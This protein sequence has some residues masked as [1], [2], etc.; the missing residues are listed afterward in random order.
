MIKCKI[1][2][3]D[4]KSIMSLAR[5]VTQAHKICVNEYYDIYLNI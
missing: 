3:K 1:C 2:E 4:F 5:H